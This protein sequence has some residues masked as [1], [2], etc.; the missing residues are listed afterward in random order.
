VFYSYI[1]YTTS[2]SLMVYETIK[3][4]YIY[5]MLRFVSEF[6]YE[7]STIMTANHNLSWTVLV[8][9]FSAIRPLSPL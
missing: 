9:F 5:G 2:F 1:Q 7:I 4:V 3:C 8:F 6:T